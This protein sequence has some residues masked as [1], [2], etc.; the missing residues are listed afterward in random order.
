MSRKYQGLIVLNTKSIDGS[1]DDLVSSISKEIES[2]GAKIDKVAQ[3]GRREFAYEHRHLK[4]G[5]YVNYTFQASPDTIKKLQSRL[6]LNAH[7]HLQHYS[8]VA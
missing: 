1:V 6:S 4:A 2:E 3:L 5:H 7:V 8:R